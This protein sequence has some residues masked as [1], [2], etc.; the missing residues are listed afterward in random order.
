MP[1][2][3]CLRKPQRRESYQNEDLED[4]PPVPF[5]HNEFPVTRSL[6]WAIGE[7]NVS[8]SGFGRIDFR[9]SSFK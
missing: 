1:G 7:E 6:L 9:G 8:L 5:P 2:A 4:Y 3:P